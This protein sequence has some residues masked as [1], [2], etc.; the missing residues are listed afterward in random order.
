MNTQR[1]ISD[2]DL[3]AY[4][5]NRLDVTRHGEVEAYIQQNPEVAR[6]VEGFAG[7]REMLRAALRPI[8]QEPVPSQLSLTRLIEARRRPHLGWRWLAAAAVIVFTVGMGSGWMARGSLVSPNSGIAALAVDASANYRVFTTDKTRP[9]EIRADDPEGLV[10]WISN[11]IQRPISVPDLSASGF[12]FMGGRVVATSQGAAGLL[13]YD[14]EQ[15]ARITLLVRPMAV[16]RDMRMSDLSDGSVAVF[17]WADAGLGYGV[18]GALQP[19]QLHPIADEIR[20]QIDKE[21]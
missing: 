14:N 21:V 2:D 11:R 12:R 1:P 19:G 20:R 18:A 4:V 15:G 16:G 13:M 8:A 17:A 6:R 9:V 7:Q 10:K 3:H 5:D